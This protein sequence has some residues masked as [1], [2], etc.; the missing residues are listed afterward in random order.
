MIA[1]QHTKYNG[2]FEKG[3]FYGGIDTNP[4]LSK[5]SD[6]KVALKSGVEQTAVEKEDLT[7]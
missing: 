7:L 6:E 4:R 2:E 5:D 3:Q 1:S